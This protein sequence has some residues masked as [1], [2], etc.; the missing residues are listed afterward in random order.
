MINYLVYDI[1][2]FAEDWIV[3][4]YNVQTKS[5]HVIHND[6]KQ[7]QKIF[8]KE[9]NRL[10]VGFNNKHYDDY[11]IL[12]ML[13]G[14]SNS[15]IKEHNDWIISGKNPWEFPFIQYQKK[16]FYSSDLRDDLPINLS[17][18]AIEANMNQSIVET[19]VPFDI[20]RK[21]TK[22]ELETEIKYCS[23]DVQNTARLLSKRQR[24]LYAKFTLAQ[25]KNF[26]PRYALSLTNAKLTAAFLDAKKHQYSDEF[27]YSI[28]KN[29]EI[30][31]YQEVLEFF[32]APIEFTKKRLTKELQTI[33]SK[34]KTASLERQ[35][36]ELTNVYQTSLD[37]KIAGVPHTYAWGGLHGA[38]SNYFIKADTKH[39]I[40]TVDVSSY[41]PSLMIQY[42]YLSRNVP[43]PKK[44]E[45]VYHQRIEAK[46]NGDKPTANALKLVLNTTYGASKNQYNDLF[47]PRQAN[48]ICVNGQLLLTDLI[49]KL[50]AVSSFELIQTN[51]DGIIIRFLKSKESE[52]EQVLK[53]WENRTHLSMERTIM[54]VIAQKDVNNYVM[55]KGESYVYQD[56]KKIVIEPD[57]DAIKTKGGYVSLYEGGDFRNKSLVVL[58]KALV[59]FFMEGVEPSETIEKDN[60]VTDFQLIAKTGSTYDKTIWEVDGKDIEVQR[61]NRV[62]ATKDNLKGSLFK[63]KNNGRRDKISNLPEHCDIDNDNTQ[64]I[65]QI[66]K[67][68]YIDLAKK[69]IADYLGNK[70]IKKMPA[71]KKST[72]KKTEEL[73]IS[74][75]NLFQKLS[76]LRVDFLN[77]EVKKSGINRFAEYKYFE[78]E[79]IV[80]IA[81]RLLDK[82][83]LT[84]IVSFT[85]T[86]A[87]MRVVDQ[88]SAVRDE[89]GISICDFEDFTSPM[90]ELS[91]KG[92]NAIQAMGA[93]ETYQRRY[94]YFMLLDVVEHDEIDAG[95]STEKVEKEK[96]KTPAKT[97]TSKRPASATE[98]KSDKEK[99]TNA[100][101][102]MDETVKKAIIKG[103]K[104]LRAKDDKYEPFIAKAK[105][106]IKDGLT[107]KQGEHLL[108]KV[109]AKVAE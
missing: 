58:N 22:Q 79:D 70:E 78:L 71:T 74:K 33:K 43:N 16:P 17:L 4:I 51:T 27:D 64:K 13:N 55:K 108:E 84:A 80:P 98:R 57:V 81:T 72:T 103:L 11:I 101:G 6:L 73:D 21:L 76:K 19:G 107:Q 53:A 14:G 93:V 66:D 5:T 44:F 23:S 38:R 42:Q 45:E 109:G 30:G 32:K 56:G 69:R 99:I 24:Y 29:L 3:I 95:Q 9:D 36:K 15:V 48:A 52:I 86:Q 54:K 39:K 18:K 88:D 87:R 92:M 63:I 37:T 100:D 59:N 75:L 46:N 67:Q 49:D 28:N 106:K 8:N 40:L 68:F 89:R 97:T 26:E 31:K 7:V 82:Y 34:G 35:L 102:E 65:E 83:H 60:T 77:E 1:E 90:V 85:D 2:V 61:V 105:E 50:E 91:V 47:D 96:P 25:I 104:K 12:T 20:K 10:F 62:Y 41:Y 94:L